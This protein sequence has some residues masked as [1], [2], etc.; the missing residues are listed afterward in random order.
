[1]TSDWRMCKSHFGISISCQ[2][3]F[4]SCLWKVNW[5]NSIGHEIAAMFNHL[6]WISRDKVRLK[7]F[8]IQCSVKGW[9]R[10]LFN[11]GTVWNISAELTFLLLL[12]SFWCVFDFVLVGEHIT[13]NCNLME[14]FIFFVRVKCRKLERI[15]L[16]EWRTH[17]QSDG[18]ST[19]G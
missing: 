6:M 8:Q 16:L 13:W 10:L 9:N 12:R 7:S 17:F 2:N 11:N 18:E 15:Q 14:S 5:N 3:H 4:D 19:V 1:M